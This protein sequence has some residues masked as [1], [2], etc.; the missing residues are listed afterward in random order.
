MMRL[1]KADYYAPSSLSEACSILA[2]HGEEAKVLGGGTDLLVACKLRN[3]NPALLVSLSSISE[4]KGIH[5]NEGEYLR[6]GAMTSLHDL[7]CDSLISDTYPAL[8]QA[9]A[10]VGT[11]QLQYM[12]TIGGNLCL[13]TRC[14]YYNQSESWRRSRD[15]CFKMGGHLC[16]VVPKGKKCYAVFSGDTVPAL[17]ALD[18][19]VKLVS[20]T[21][22]RW[23][24][25]SKLYTGDGKEPLA[26]KSGE[27]VS[28]IRLPQPTKSQS[29]TYLKYRTRES[30]DFPMAGV[31]VR[32]DTSDEG[33]CT[34][35]RV[36]LNAVD[37]G[38]TEV[39]EARE[40]LEG[41]A[42]TSDLIQEVAAEA[43]KKAHP[44]ANTPGSTPAYR[45]KLAGILTHRALHQ[46]ANRLG[47]V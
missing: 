18:A 4:L 43:E 10:L 17:I 23:V 47:M 5:F 8:S 29:S 22:E 11:T 32:M 40:L 42:P 41:K 6:I 37:C 33:I 31:A 28:E 21:E 35:C 25:V 13:N 20:N 19:E 39:R 34:G 36:V 46:V 2:E 16:H 1:P 30:I 9:A 45:R 15:V 27:L 3:V 7:R 14:I 38:P 12:G 24:S 44:V 26:L